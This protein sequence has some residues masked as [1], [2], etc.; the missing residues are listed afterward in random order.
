MIPTTHNKIPDPLFLPVYTTRALTK[1]SEAEHLPALV[2]TEGRSCESGDQPSQPRY[3]TKDTI[4][5]EGK[6]RLPSTEMERKI[7]E[8]WSELLSVDA[9]E[10]GL[11]DDF[12]SLGGDCVRAIQ[13]VAA[14]RSNSVSLT[15]EDVLRHPTLVEISHVA[16]NIGPCQE[17]ELTPF[18]LL[19]GLEA[20]EAICSDAIAQCDVSRDMVEDIYPCTPLQEGIFALST[21]TSGAYIT[22]RS[23]PLPM[24]L[25]I[26]RFRN[27]WEATVRSYAILRTTIVQ[28]KIGM[29][30]VVLK[31]N[32]DWLAADSV[33][34][35]L[36]QDRHIPIYLG[37]QLTRYAVV[38]NAAT[39]ARHFVWT[40][41]HAVS[42]AWSVR[43]I[44]ENVDRV[45]DGTTSTT[46][47]PFNSF[48]RYLG[49]IDKSTSE[50]YWRSQLSGASPSTLFSAPSVRYQTQVNRALE[51]EIHIVRKSNSNTTISTIIRAA[52]TIL[53][54][55]Y[56]DSSDV[57][58]GVTLTGRDAPNVGIEGMIGPT[59]TTVPIRIRFDQE[60]MVSEFLRDVQTQAATMIPF[61]HTGLQ[62]IR[63]VSQDA[64]EAC[65]FSNLLVTHPM[66]NEIKGLF[67]H[68][69]RFRSIANFDTYTLVME[70]TLTLNGIRVTATFDSN[71]IE[72]RQMER[73]MLQFE[74][75]IQQLCLEDATQ[76][77]GEVECM[78]EKEKEEVWEWNDT[79]PEA[80]DAL[81]H[82]LIEEQVQ[83]QPTSPAVCSWDGQLSYGELNRLSSKLSNYLVGLGVGPEV[84]VPLC[85]EK[86]M[87][88]VVAMLAVMKT[89]GAFALLDGSHPRRRLEVMVGEIG[90]EIM[91]TSMTYVELSLSLSK[92]VV[93]VNQ[94]EVGRLES[95]TEQVEQQQMSSAAA[96]YVVFTS[97]STGKPKGVVISHSNYCSGLVQR[98]KIMGFKPTSRMFDFASYSFDASLDNILST[99]FA[100]G[101]VCTPS[102]A[103]RTD[104]VV[105]AMNRLNVNMAALTASVARLISPEAVPDLRVLI[106]GGEAIAATD[107]HVW[108][109]R[110]HLFNAYGPAECSSISNA[111]TRVT[112]STH[113][114]NIGRGL[115]AVL[116]VTDATD[117]NQLSPIGAVGELLIEGPI[118][119][120]GYLNDQEK[121]EAAFIKDPAWLLAGVGGRPGRRGRLYKTG[122]LV[123]YN[124]DGSISFV[125]RKD[126]QI[127]L[128]GQRIELGE[129]EHRLRQILPAGTEIAAEMIT[130]AGKGGQPA[131][132]AF[133]AVGL[134]EMPQEG[135]EVEVCNAAMR[136]QLE[137]IVAELDEKLAD[138]L[139]SFMLPSAYIPVRQMPMTVSVKTDRKRLREM[140]SSLSMKQLT[141]FKTASD[142][143]REPLTEM[144]RRLQKL[145]AATLSLDTEKIGASDSFLRIGGDSITAMWLVAVAREQGLSLTVDTIFRHPRLFE[146]A[147]EVKLVKD[148]VTEDVAPFRL[149]H[150][151]LDREGGRLNAAMHCNVTA[152]QIED[153]FP[154]TPLQQGLLAMTVKRAGDYVAR[155]VFEL[156]PVTDIE[157]FKRAWE[158]TVATTS[159]LRT[160]I[161]DLR[162]QG[163]VQVVVDERVAWLVGDDLDAYVRNDEER[164]MELGYALSRHALIEDRRRNK[165]FFILTI[166]H[167]LYDGWSVPLI[168]RVAQQSYYGDV[169]PRLVPFQRFVKHILEIDQDAAASFW[170]SQLASSELVCFPPLP[171]PTYQPQADEL[172]GIDL[173]D[174]SQIGGDITMST[175]VR[176]AWG[177]LISR[178]C[179][180]NTAIFGGIVTGRQA[181]V[182]G[183]EWIIGPTIAT[184]PLL[185]ILDPNESVMQLLQRVQAQGIDM[186]QFEQ[187]GLSQIRQ[188]GGDA[189]Q[190]C[191][192]QTLL[193]VEPMQERNADYGLFT[194]TTDDKTYKRMSETDSFTT[195][196]MMLL[197]QLQDQSLHLQISFDST[198]V[199][200][201][202]VERMAQ[203]FEHI[204]RQLCME[205]CQT[206]K[207]KDIETVSQQ[208]LRDIWQWN[209]SVPSAVEMCMHDLIAETTRRQP[210]AAAICAWDG[211]ITYRQLDEMSTRLAHHL[212]EYGVG[213]DVVVPLCFEKSMWMP[214]AALAVMKAGGASI[215]MDV[216]QP[217]ERLQ[218]I[219]QQVSPLAI[220]SSSAYEARAR[221]LGAATVIKVDAEQIHQIM[222]PSATQ[223]PKV[224]P[225]NRICVVFTSGSTG[226]PKGAIL[227]HR[228]FSTFTAS[229]I[230]AFDLTS[231]SR[232]YDFS[233]YSF[234]FAWANL[235]CTI[236][237]GACLCIPSESQ[238]INDFV[239]SM[240]HFEATLVFLTPSLFRTLNP[241][242]LPYLETIIVGGE[243]LLKTDVHQWLDRAK[244]LNI[245]GP[246]ECTVM[247][248][249]LHV[250]TTFDN[251][252]IGFGLATN[253]WVVNPADKG[254]RLASIG[255]EGELYLEGPL[256][257]IGYLNDPESTAAAFIEDPSW[258]L[259]GGEGGGRH[260]RLYKTGDLVRYNA[261]GSLTFIGRTDTQVKIRGQRVELSEV[262]H[263]V[264]Q[265]LVDENAHIAA[266][267]IQVVAEMVT[268]Q[269][270]DN[271]VLVVFIHL[272]HDDAGGL[273]GEEDRKATV[274]GIT[275]GLEDRLSEKLPAY[276]IASAYIPIEAIPM[277]ASGKADRRLLRERGSLTF[278]DRELT[279]QHER[280]TP[281][282][283][284]ETTLLEVWMEV[285]NLPAEAISTDTPFWRLGGDSITG[286]QV[287][288]RCRARKIAILLRD[289]LREQ[290]IRQSAHC[291]TLVAQVS[292]AIVDEEER[293]WRLSPIQQ[294]FFDIY[295]KGLNHFNQSLLLKLTRPVSGLTLRKALETLV[296]RHSMLRARFR[297]NQNGQWEQF[298]AK[299]T[300]QA[301]AFTE[302]TLRQETALDFII[303]EQQE[304]LNISYGPVFA[305]N[306]CEAPGEG[307][308][309]FLVAHHLVVDLV[310]WRI[311]MHDI[312]H[313]IC[314]G[315][316]FHGKPLPFQTWTK[317]QYESSRPLDPTEVLPFGTIVSQFEYWNLSWS[318]N[319][320]GEAEY[321]KVPLDA[322]TTSLLVG[323]GN[324][325]FR[326]EPVDILVATLVHSFRQAFP[327]R[328]P[329]AIFLEGHGREPLN[330]TEIDPS[331]TVGWF[332]TIHPLQIPGKV[333]DTTTEM[334]KFTKDI[335]R[336]VPGKGRPYFACRYQNAQ[337]REEF[338][339]H[340]AMEL[341]FNYTGI[342]QQLESENSPFQP[343]DRPE[344]SK[345]GNVSSVAQRIALIEITAG[346]EQGKLNVTF[347]VNRR[348]QHQARL[349]DWA[350]LYAQCLKLT[351][352]SLADQSMSW[353]L[354]DFPLLPLSY[355]GLER[356]VKDWL[357]DAGVDVGN[358]HD[359]YPCTPIQEGILLSRQKEMASYANFW[360]WLCVPVNSGEPI[361]P[362]RLTEAW[363]R[364]VQRH[365][366]LASTFAADLD[367]GRFI[368]VLLR[369][370]K[371]RVVY[372]RVQSRRPDEMLLKM[373]RPLFRPGE[374]E[375]A[376]TIC[377]TVDGLVACRLDISHALIDAASVSILIGDLAKTYSGTELCPAPLF[378]DFVQYIGHTARSEKLAYWAQFLQDVQPCE[379]PTND[380]LVKTDNFELIALSAPATSRIDTFCRDREIT[381]SVF[382][383]IA[384]ALVLSRYT[385]MSQVCFGYIASGR[386]APIDRIEQMVGPLISM[387]ISRINLR[388]P[389]KE[390]AAIA[391][392]NSVEHL[393]FQHMS[394]AEILRGLASG[395]KR[396]FNTAMSVREGDRR[397]DIGTENI[398][399]ERI[400]VD[401]PH[402]VR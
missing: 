289:L 1:M 304:S 134:D 138:C 277:T 186:I 363:T 52:W 66:I 107:I 117:H 370:P 53:T 56:I 351:V 353:T 192:F 34:T 19:R 196:A 108:A 79:V 131:L 142:K 367:S 57:L 155:F 25:D 373:K 197:C 222:I 286:M 63:R 280:L 393:A 126:T 262:E 239:G 146:L 358:V 269:G 74:G 254:G 193:V 377:E 211:E 366:I 179:N 91:L 144:E 118:L 310:S 316:A 297:Q 88:T 137:P 369:D 265:L 7:R 365:S 20:T 177:L 16:T 399:F 307:Q 147:Q 152:E 67:G 185:L 69:V 35:Y 130:P 258:L 209:A 31:R 379:F 145:W 77:V 43:L 329:P 260:G 159:I 238:R 324:H 115:G 244:V 139:P 13:L 387:L 401:D 129:V 256:V 175:A 283:S 55:R 346:V 188:L 400:A 268:P 68:G 375:H 320:Y 14:A 109:N 116:W 343:I 169:L 154:C 113:P 249:C 216:T 119:A 380:T 251:R 90:A 339:Q 218:S 388:G 36:E 326:T 153:I 172:L 299:D 243:V 24:S 133:V 336:R 352:S 234:D 163:L 213:L 206:A 104:N 220:L 86:S 248:T 207:V 202:L 160:R 28:T 337:G 359:L 334:V 356:L 190:A 224:I 327:D 389:L 384:W 290:T 195:Y 374:P 5:A 355:G 148:S 285:L 371:P 385:G 303:E 161:V 288:S 263:H 275:A 4:T 102:N 231:T 21:K 284:V 26:D 372:D 204:L 318:D 9:S 348:M 173:N 183:V 296:T 271:S 60:Q 3:W 257:G 255:E 281:S 344:T 236:S 150:P 335:R 51:R 338:K 252:N 11:D 217:Q 191:R 17:A 18:S 229:S 241:N 228:N 165:T 226:V 167:A 49:G 306:L 253:L 362:S 378:R 71:V 93:V 292:P 123:R 12:L 395:G 48:I 41:H 201:R 33:E 135:D 300:P 110:L 298:I 293:A 205:K 364:T 141:A 122:D 85:F 112:A 2:L 402:E 176:T 158:E 45:Y 27:A 396:I 95:G 223:L 6:K 72:S 315:N 233:S 125:G 76:Q 325:C 376:F 101:C 200:P 287:V 212:V 37:D 97:G 345:S 214:I 203:Q 87:W 199:E 219:I 321:Y 80:V 103:E 235:L 100:G 273:A 127:K 305:A 267:G 65:K 162:D 368:Q 331:E 120:R 386:D 92:H 182:S 166:H 81:M 39:R 308:I 89:G 61:E 301:F 312:K 361:S 30:Q 136:S 319:T 181:A 194:T 59:I 121:T 360:V 132:V 187:T 302:H 62:N 8:L 54:A 168:L 295:P 58:F 383:Q 349:R 96:L 225:S 264:R 332:T 221:Q 210:E 47:T 278:C 151:D 313:A 140:G 354:S 106:L 259:R 84:I 242:M 394:L 294:M 157:R 382:L 276:M 124:A 29:M 309:L 342:F 114:G 266:N 270:A 314:N 250:Q 274:Q 170:Q 208:D 189:E 282:N 350:E 156:Q 78:S 98:A 390:I 164:I 99:L 317:L 82:Q 391:L 246:A 381:R 198:V 178:Y 237:S 230:S 180:S 40:I 245:Y 10:I 357:P 15:V 50:S 232:V 42:D 143:K 64:Y 75:I 149:L 279:R 333:S 44:L 341:I 38:E 128:R 247:T 291:C 340:A 23:I 322:Q 184:V 240:N 215:A 32:I 105:G 174:I 323:N 94:A 261:D 171:S 111:N 392:K 73:I 83:I 46:A 328:E 397:E 22:R 70:C 311:L 398:R 227:T 272:D 330:D 347:C